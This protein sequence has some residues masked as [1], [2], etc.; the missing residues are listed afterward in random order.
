[1]IRECEVLRCDHCPAR[2]SA[3]HACERK[4]VWMSKEKQDFLFVMNRDVKETK[5]GAEGH[6][7]PLF[8]CGVD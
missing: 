6:Q 4:T 5:L 7:A 1:M 3:W 8:D 2:I